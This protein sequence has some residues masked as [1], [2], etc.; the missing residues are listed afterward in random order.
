MAK[1]RTHINLVGN[2][3]GIPTKRMKARAKAKARRGG[4][5]GVTKS[6]GLSRSAR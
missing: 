1:K 3:T 6:R 4:R 2:S 5:A